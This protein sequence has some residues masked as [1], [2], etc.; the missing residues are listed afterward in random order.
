MESTCFIETCQPRLRG[1]LR[2]DRFPVWTALSGASASATFRSPVQGRSERGS[3]WWGGESVT[4]RVRGSLAG[5]QSS[6]GASDSPL[7]VVVAT[8]SGEAHAETCVRPPSL[9]THSRPSHSLLRG[10]D[11]WTPALL[12]MRMRQVCV[13]RI[14]RTDVGCPDLAAPRTPTI[15]APLGVESRRQPTPA[16]TAIE[17]PP[18]ACCGV[19]V[20]ARHD[21]QPSIPRWIRAEGR[22]LS[23]S[24]DLRSRNARRWATPVG[25]A[26]RPRSRNQWLPLPASRRFHAVG[27]IRAE[28]EDAGRRASSLI[29]A[30][31]I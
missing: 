3:W 30:T 22:G 6:L 15:R 16:A 12:V 19:A 9:V 17:F 5:L 27:G 26:D 11:R 7:G 1:A 21:P 10:G 13:A 4:A 24:G 14:A 18:P 31:P 8:V 20:D 29:H 2:P 28:G 25:A 23:T